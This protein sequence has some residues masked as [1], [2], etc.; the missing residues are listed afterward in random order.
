MV[1]EIRYHEQVVVKVD[2][3]RQL[4]LR[5]QRFIR[6]L[7]PRKTRLEDQ[8]ALPERRG[9]PD[10]PITYPVS[11]RGLMPSMGDKGSIQGE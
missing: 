5:N 3:S 9:A 8:F 2:G 6:E 4:T 7:D 10:D 11:W 1:V